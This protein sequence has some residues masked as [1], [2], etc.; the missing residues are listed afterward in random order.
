MIPRNNFRATGYVM[1]TG[2]G[3]FL[4]LANNNRKS[5]ISAA[6]W[7]QRMTKPAESVFFKLFL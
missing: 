7:I 5:L 6:K 3:V 2:A 4:L 1:L